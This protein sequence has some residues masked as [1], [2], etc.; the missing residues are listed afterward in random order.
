MDESLDELGILQGT[1]KS[2]VGHGYLRHYERLFKDFRHE[3]ITLVEIGVARGASLR[4]WAEYFDR[5]T[6]VGIDIQQKC[7]QYGGGR[8][9]VEIGSQG[10]ADFLNDL[11]KRRRP[12]IL[13]DDGSHQ[14][15]HII[16]SF[17]TLFP[18]L[19][20]GGIYVVEDL[21]FHSD[22]W[23]KERR[24]SSEVAPQDYF[25]RFAN[26]ISC[27]NLQDTADRDFAYW[28]EAMEFFYGGVVIR[29]RPAPEKDPVAK[30]RNLVERANQAE[31]WGNFAN[32]IINHGGDFAEAMRAVQRAMELEPQE[33]GHHHRLSFV[34]E[35]GGDL[36]G[37]LAAAREAA[38]MKPAFAMFQDRVEKLSAKAER[39]H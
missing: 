37:A 13:I 9:D 39:Q 22:P 1:D 29:K 16:L 27:P 4:M 24:G 8:C 12:H 36:A 15:D 2:S 7:A 25:L 17:R 38:R 35:R 18:H 30:R 23:A 28:I 19:R 3:P 20:E 32:Y 14:A 34:L 6:I 5:G 10:D 21:H 33:A 31:L 11:G 26:M